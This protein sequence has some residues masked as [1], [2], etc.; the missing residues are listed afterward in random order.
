MKMKKILAILFLSIT[1][2]SYSQVLKS[3]AG[4]M[5]KG[6][7]QVASEKSIKFNNQKHGISTTEYSIAFFDMFAS[8]S[9]G[10][11]LE[12]WGHGREKLALFSSQNT[13]F[14]KEEINVILTRL[15]ANYTHFKKDVMA[16]GKLFIHA[17]I[18][19]Q[20]EFIFSAYM[21]FKSPKYAFWYHGEKYQVTE[22]KLLMLMTKMELYFKG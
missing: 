12:L 1:T 19:L 4:L 10:D 6:D 7:G 20:P 2:V 15:R 13:E 17:D 16:K 11:A 9:G 8:T 14:S 18:I 21:D 5:D 22:K 3:V